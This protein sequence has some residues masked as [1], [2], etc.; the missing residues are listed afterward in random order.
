MGK[1]GTTLRDMLLC[2]GCSGS[3]FECI[4][5]LDCDGAVIPRITAVATSMNLT[6]FVCLPN[7]F[8]FIENSI[9]GCIWWRVIEITTSGE[10]VLDLAASFTT[11]RL[12]TKSRNGSCRMQLWFNGE[13]CCTYCRWH[14]RSL[15]FLSLL[16]LLSFSFLS[17]MV[18]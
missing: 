14:L 10:T 6:I 18:G 3:F 2:K 16:T 11:N 4:I 1:Y 7:C 15:F 9:A 13:T 12:G 8:S 17:L 5:L